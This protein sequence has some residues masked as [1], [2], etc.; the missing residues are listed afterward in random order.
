M[1]QD[2]DWNIWGAHVFFRDYFGF[3]LL[4]YTDEERLGVGLDMG[5][6]T[7][8]RHDTTTVD[9]A[10]DAERKVI[11]A[12][13]CTLLLLSSKPGRQTHRRRT[14][15]LISG[16]CGVFG[17]PPTRNPTHSQC[18]QRLM[19]PLW[20]LSE[21]AGGLPISVDGREGGPRWA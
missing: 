7:R 18:R 16:G 13:T 12:H 15:V 11:Q 8:E 5:W 21:Q 6:T 9:I 20:C 19:V 4:G 2:G 14:P 10:V 1:R 3:V 17:E